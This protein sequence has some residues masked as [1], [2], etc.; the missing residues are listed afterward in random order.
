MSALE[1]LNT[2]IASAPANLQPVLSQ[3]GRITQELKTQLGGHATDNV[4]QFDDVSTRM[5]QIAARA[6]D[7]ENGITSINTTLVTISSKFDIVD[8]FLGS[9]TALENVPTIQTIMDEVQAMKTV[10]NDLL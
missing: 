3:L 6:S 5:T 7:L 8:Q 9:A 2:L 1:V 10:I 4:A